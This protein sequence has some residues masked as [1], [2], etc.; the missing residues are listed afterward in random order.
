MKNCNFLVQSILFELRINKFRNINF[1]EGGLAEIIKRHENFKENLNLIVNYLVDALKT[2]N[3]A[4]LITVLNNQ[5]AGCDNDNYLQTIFIDRLSV[6]IELTTSIVMSNKSFKK[7]HRLKKLERSIEETFYLIYNNFKSFKAFEKIIIISY[8]RMKIVEKK[9][10][11]Y[12]WIEDKSFNKLDKFFI[13]ASKNFGIFSPLKT[14][15]V[16]H[17]NSIED[18]FSY[19]NK[20]KRSIIPLRVLSNHNFEVYSQFPDNYKKPQKD[21]YSYMMED[22]NVVKSVVEELVTA[23]PTRQY[24]VL[25][26]LI[27][28]IYL[29]HVK[30]QQHSEKM[31]ES[32]EN[33]IKMVIVKISSNHIKWFVKNIFLNFPEEP[34]LQVS[35]EMKIRTIQMRLLI[36]KMLS[37]IVSLRSRDNDLFS[38]F[39]RTIRNNNKS[40]NFRFMFN[41]DE[42]CENNIALLFGLAS[43]G[44]TSFY[45]C[46]CGYI[47]GIG[48]CGQAW[49]EAVCP[50]CKKTIGGKSHRLNARSGH[51]K[52]NE[53]FISNK[54]KEPLM[55]Y[56]IKYYKH[57]LF[58]EKKVASDSKKSLMEGFLYRIMHL[59]TH[60]FYMASIYFCKKEK[61]FKRLL[62]K[63]LDKPEKG[64]STENK[65]NKVLLG[66]EAH[67]QR[68]LVY[69]RGYLNL[70]ETPY[71]YFCSLIYPIRQ[72][73]SQFDGNLTQ[74]SFV[75]FMK[76]I[77]SAPLQ[78]LLKFEIYMSNQVKVILEY[79][80][81]TKD[82]LDKFKQD[83]Q[84]DE[85][86]NDSFRNDWILCKSTYNKVFKQGNNGILVHNLRITHNFNFK[87]FT[88]ELT[89][90]TGN[91]KYLFLKYYVQHKELVDGI[92]GEILDLHLKIAT[93][94]NEKYPFCFTKEHLR[95]LKVKHLTSEW[96]RK[97]LMEDKDFQNFQDA[98]DTLLSVKKQKGIKVDKK[99]ETMYNRFSELWQLILKLQDKFPEVFNFNFECHQGVEVGVNLDRLKKKEI[100]LMYFVIITNSEELN[101]MLTIFQTCAKFQNKIIDE[102]IAP[103]GSEVFIEDVPLAYARPLDFFSLESNYLERL[104]SL[105][106]FND[107]SFNN[108]S[109]VNFN[110]KRIEEILKTKL[111]ANC[112][113]LLYTR[114]HLDSYPIKGE[115]DETSRLL[116]DLQAVVKV[117]KLSAD[118]IS[119]L[120]SFSVETIRCLEDEIA[121]VLFYIL[122]SGIRNPHMELNKFA[123][124]NEV[125]ISQEMN[126]LNMDLGMIYDLYR[127][128][129]LKLSFWKFNNQISSIYKAKLTPE[130]K[131]DL[132]KFKEALH[133][134]M[135]ELLTKTL[136][137]YI[138]QKCTEGNHTILP[139]N[140]FEF[141]SYTEIGLIDIECWSSP[142][143]TL[144]LIE[145]EDEDEELQEEKPEPVTFTFKQVFTH[146]KIFEIL[147][148]LEA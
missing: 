73:H 88:T 72:A 139:L 119:K 141:M 113:K 121:K 10:Q 19:A 117:S 60:L 58:S 130:E 134:I 14:F 118:S 78:K 144:A 16:Q 62:K 22:E 44:A 53:D 13:V 35:C 86:K 63:F 114:E 29:T 43:S 67:I 110:F 32:F 46:S 1:L 4:S 64:M 148:T 96:T 66:F 137:L 115:T 61:G 20:K 145:N 82:A 5:F 90:R 17:L 107:P 8:L 89:E 40:E 94:F 84:K 39:I 123:S 25:E 120:D 79:F 37:N 138:N 42:K 108:A 52:I 31:K 131:Q 11:L 21:M 143:V 69:L 45:K 71:D 65:I 49:V 92:I 7:L 106:A 24:L 55:K 75:K 57:E 56:T 26:F 142:E 103:E 97:Q 136:R 111:A 33:N 91:E 68:D 132:N 28:K 2:Q 36:V 135:L 127:Q 95:F 3:N 47:Y 93:Y 18:V 15:L 38:C 125:G 27:N 48:N 133:P 109:R 140:L 126:A 76:F 112:R 80:Q 147:Q 98:A 81:E 54:Y 30:S 12:Q 59:Y 102:F 104:V 124:K 34:D 6:E 77:T 116:T 101:M 74:N 87:D 85:S 129:Q 146:E 50:S 122:R 105:Y 23:D 83:A 70:S 99:L 51:E 100:N 41:Y 9:S 128:V